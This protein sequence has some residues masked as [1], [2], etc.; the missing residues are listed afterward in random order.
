MT[1]TASPTSSITETTTQT[2]TTTASATTTT[3]TLVPSCGPSTVRGGNS[4]DCS[5]DVV[6]GVELVADGTPISVTPVSDAAACVFGCDN[7]NAWLGASFDSLTKLCTLVGDFH[8]VADPL[9]AGF[10]FISGSCAGS[11]AA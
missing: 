5:Y 6:C 8:Q 3:T 4:C 7:L 9:D 2:T 10:V 1:V 11:C